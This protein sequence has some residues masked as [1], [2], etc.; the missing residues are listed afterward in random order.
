MFPATI[1]TVSGNNKAHGG[2]LTPNPTLEAMIRIVQSTIGK[3]K[4]TFCAHM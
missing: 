2:T 1:Y 4:S 3:T